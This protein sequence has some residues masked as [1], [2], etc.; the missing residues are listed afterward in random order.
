MVAAAAAGAMAERATLVLGGH[1]GL[2]QAQRSRTSEGRA[3]DAQLLDALQVLLQVAIPAVRVLPF[4][5]Q[6]GLQLLCKLHHGSL[7]PPLAGLH[8]HERNTIAVLRVALIARELATCSAIQ[9]IHWLLCAYSNSQ[10]D[11]N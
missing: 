1:Q 9:I 2:E 11:C 10:S 8:R 3:H 4:W 5:H 7:R 6:L